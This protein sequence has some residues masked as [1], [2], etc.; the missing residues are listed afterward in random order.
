MTYKSELLTQEAKFITCSG[1][2]SPKKF[3]IMHPV[4]RM[5]YDLQINDFSLTVFENFYALINY[6]RTN[7]IQIQARVALYCSSD[8]QFEIGQVLEGLSY[9]GDLGL[10]FICFKNRQAASDWLSE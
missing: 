6:V 3:L 1:V 7:K 10:Q 4:P 5:L 2:F 8:Y 9:V